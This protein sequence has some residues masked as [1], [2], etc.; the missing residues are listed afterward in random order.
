MPVLIGLDVLLK[1]KKRLCQKKIKYTVNEL[2]KINSKNKFLS[3]EVFSALM[4]V[5]LYGVSNGIAEIPKLVENDINNIGPLTRK[6]CESNV[7]KADS[8]VNV[9]IVSEHGRPG[10][11]NWGEGFGEIEG[12]HVWL[13]M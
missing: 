5:N 1:F 7:L 8:S 4:S 3:K 13:R 12:W 10:I 2:K 11:F 9:P 6:V